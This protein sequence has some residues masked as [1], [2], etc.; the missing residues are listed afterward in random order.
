MLDFE[1]FFSECAGF[2]ATERT[3][4]S[5][6]DADV[7]RSHTTF[8]VDKLTSVDKQKMISGLAAMEIPS[9]GI[10]FSPKLLASIVILN[11]GPADLPCPGFSIAFDTKSE[12]GETVSMALNALFIPDTYF[13]T[14]SGESVVPLPL[15]AEVDPSDGLIQGV[16]LRDRGYYESSAIAG[17]FTYQP[18]RQTLEMTTHYSRSVAVDQMRFITPTLRLR[19]IVTYQRP[20]A[21]DQAPSVISLVGFGVEHKSEAE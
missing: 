17:W 12:R 18:T 20:E 5:I 21:D 10:S 3:Y 11:S 14:A 19:T 7:E 1:Q 9:H 6:Q 15:A 2:W 4:H 16:Y 8:Q 13:S